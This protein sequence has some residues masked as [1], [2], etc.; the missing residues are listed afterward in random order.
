MKT[1][2]NRKARIN[3]HSQKIGAKLREEVSRSRNKYEE[4][5]LDI[6]ATLLQE[7]GTL[8]LMLVHE[9]LEREI[10]RL[11]GDRYERTAS[12]NVRHGSNPGSIY[13]GGRKIKTRIP[14]VRNRQSQE[15]VPLA[16]L[17]A[18]R[19]E[20]YRHDETLFN[21]VLLGVSCHRYEEAAD[22]LPGALGLSASSVS[23]KFKKVSA[24]RLA[25]LNT[26]DLSCHDFVGLVLDGKSCAKELMFIAVGITIDGKKIPLGL[27]Q[28]GTENEKA[29]SEFLKSLKDRGLNTSQGLLAVID[30]SKGICAAVEKTF[31][32]E[33]VIQ[34]CQWHKRENVV[35]YLKKEEQEYFRARLQR[36]YEN[37]AYKE[38][39]HAL[40]VLAKELSLK[41]ISAKNSLEEGL[42][43]TLTLHRLGV[44][45]ELGF[46]LK[47]TNIL[48]SMNSQIE[49]TCGKVKYY[50]NSSQRLR[51][52]A[53]A[54]LDIESCLH[55]INGYKELPKLRA[56][57]K[58][59]LK[60]NEVN[61]RSM[62]ETA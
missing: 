50:R 61:D 29:I 56:A 14:R 38:A 44:F 20:G 10:S 6:K 16:S 11:V 1:V 33:V 21:R 45:R 51:W 8:G 22:A 24:K 9:E 55:R 15:E 53:A 34:R 17:E 58:K 30:G 41:N 59:E 49:L 60:L 43:A 36:A 62:K 5:P 27:A 31:A 52:Y 35:S 57:I 32:R 4:Q 39:K 40:S 37:P 7:F 2:T 54:L 26:R 3:G 46:S 19:Q 13:L 28:M 12:P 25:E 18:I 47:T 42:E 48:E 23:R